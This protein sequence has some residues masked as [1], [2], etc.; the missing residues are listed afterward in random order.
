MELR[1][2]L[3][4]GSRKKSGNFLSEHCTQSYTTSKASKT[5]VLFIN[6]YILE[7]DFCEEVCVFLVPLF[8]SEP[9][10]MLL[11]SA[12]AAAHLPPRLIK[13]HSYDCSWGLGY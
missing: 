3:R 2:E 13:L 4:S 7:L 6:S 5:S 12:Q 1:L 8:S 11:A 9:P 10:P